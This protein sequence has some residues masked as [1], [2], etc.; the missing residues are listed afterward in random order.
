M[1]YIQSDS[2]RKLPHHFDAACTLYGAEDSGL[3]YRLTSYD[4]VA[5]GKFDLLIRTNMFVGSVEFM[6]KV[7]SRVGISDVRVPKNSNRDCEVM[8]LGEAHNRVSSGVTLFIKPSQPKLFT[9]L[10]LDGCSYSCLT[11]L[12]NETMVMAYEP[13]KERIMS[14]WRGY[15]RNHELIDCRN[16]SGDFKLSPNYKYINRVIF[17]NRDTFPCSYTIDVAVLADNETVVVE[18]N[19][20]WAIG[21]YG[22]PN[23]LYLRALKERYFQIIKNN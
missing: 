7:F 13:F 10:V 11:N 1:I 18:F 12:P 14:E 19:D 16:Y 15:V 20:M 5:S 8:T 21:N 6:T 22:I 17:E 3:K 9:G 2:E 23:D 4:E